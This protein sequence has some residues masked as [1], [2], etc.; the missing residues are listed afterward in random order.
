MKERIGKNLFKS[1]SAQIISLSVGF[2]LG[3]IV[4]KIIDEYQYAYWQIF[5]LYVGYAGVLHFGLLDGIVLRYS[6]YNYEELDKRR[7]RSQFKILLYSTSA[8]AAIAI[9]VSL[10]FFAGTTREIIILVAIGVITKNLFAY[11][12]YSFQ[13]TDRIS[14]Y[15]I[16]VIVQRLAY[17]LFVVLLLCFRVNRF[18]WYCIA[19][20]AG[21]CTG[22]VLSG[23]FNRGM[24][25]GDSLPPREA[26]REWKT[27]LLSG[28]ML[29]VANWSAMLLVGGAKMVIQW[30]WDDLT[31]GMVSFSF[32]IMS[33]FLTFVNAASVVLFPSLKRL[34]QNQL[35]SLYCSIRRILSPVL[36][37]AMFCYFPGCEILRRYLPNYS[38]SLKYLGTLLPLII[39]SSKVNLLTNNYLKAYRKEKS[40]FAINSFSVIVAF[41][42]YGVCS[43]LRNSLTSVLICTVAAVMLNSVLS[44][45]IVAKA[46]RINLGRE[47]LI[48]MLMTVLFIIYTSCLH[49]WAAYAAYAVTFG[50]YLMFHR[51]DVTALFKEMKNIIWG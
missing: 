10:V 7:I 30:R 48:E 36:F 11:N 8:M 3:F 31:F 49:F 33:V 35:P 22:I 29:M 4:P 20:L 19:D 17:G 23:F 18:E 32:N 44:E 24:Y 12:S 39:Y 37:A 34:E 9:I 21:D 27:N 46:I 5:V 25:F 43:Y 2:V 6:Q 42:A 14:K 28:A 16:L 50:I 51:R 38:T 13:I 1:F 15:A 26:L 47:I 41:A 45:L 40:M